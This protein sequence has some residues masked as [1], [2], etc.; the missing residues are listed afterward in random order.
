MSRRH[1]T[2]CEGVCRGVERI[3]LLALL[4]LARYAGLLRYFHMHADGRNVQPINL[5][6]HSLAADLHRHAVLR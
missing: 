2:K 6:L 1:L 3:A 4:M 5:D